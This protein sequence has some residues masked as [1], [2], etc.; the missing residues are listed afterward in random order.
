M[1]DELQAYCKP[2]ML[3]L[4]RIHSYMALATRSCQKLTSRLLQIACCLMVIVPR[5][6]HKE[7]LPNYT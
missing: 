6:C 5:N 7:S 3:G 1:A 2:L 4:S